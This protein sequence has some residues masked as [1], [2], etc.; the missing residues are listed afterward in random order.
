MKENEEKPTT[1]RVDVNQS[2]AINRDG[3]QKA[4]GSKEDEKRLLIN[5]ANE[6]DESRFWDENLDK[7]NEKSGLV[8]N[9]QL[10]PYIGG[11]QKYEPKVPLIF[12]DHIYR[13]NG[14][15]RSDDKMS[16]RPG[17]V[18]KWT[19]DLVYLRYPLGT[20]KELRIKNP[21][22]DGVRLY[23]HHQFLTL[24]GGMHFHQFLE[25][26]IDLMATC[27]HWDQFVRRFAKKYDKPWQA[28]LFDKD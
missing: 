14:W 18:G 10:Q 26:A 4:V 6:S 16:K 11:L 23:K 28:H 3:E 1:D 7:A 20:L 19:N 13:L 12:Y 9:P 8:T 22:V 27:Q 5:R 21:M 15:D 24:L 2:P 25:D 17:I